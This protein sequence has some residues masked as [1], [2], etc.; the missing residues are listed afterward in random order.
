MLLKHRHAK[1]ST[2]GVY[3]QDRILQQTA[4]QPGTHFAYLLDPHHK[5]LV[6]LPSSNATSHTVS[7]RQTHNTV[8]PVIDLRRRDILET[9]A[10]CPLWNIDICDDTITITGLTADTPRLPQ[11]SVSPALPPVLDLAALCTS[12]SRIT[13]TYS[14]AGLAH[15]IGSMQLGFAFAD[16][17]TAP[18]SPEIAPHHLP[19]LV[20]SLFSGAGLLDLGFV[21]EG[22]T[23]AVA[24]EKNPAAAQTYQR[25]FGHQ[26]VLSDIY[27]MPFGRFS[28]P[29]MIGGSPCQGFS[30]ANRNSHFLDN[31]QNALVKAYI[32]RIQQ[33]P[34]C[35]I[36]VL[37]NVP[38]ILT[39]GDG[40]F[41][42]EILHA[43]QDFTVTYGVLDAAD[44]GTP[45]H[46]RRAF[47][48]G[49]KIG[50]I[51]LPRPGF[52]PWRT[53]RQ[54]FHGLHATIPNQT[55]ISQP[56]PLTRQRMA[57]V[58]P[59]GNVQNIPPDLRPQGTHSDMYKRLMWDAPSVT[60][61]HPRK[62]LLLHP[63]EDR[64][65][66][67]RECAR[68]QDVPD[69]FVFTGSLDAKQQQVANG[70]PVRLSQAI[71]ATVKAAIQQWTIRTAHAVFRS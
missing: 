67:V 21:Q 57:Q 44:F 10:T 39:A 23:I 36:F 41:R 16:T 6:I 18:L 69:D 17:T 24:V 7:K 34:A 27:E 1:S 45:Q 30:N 31:P 52:Q 51:A 33:N 71:A 68:L 49:S 32:D 40:Q 12:R 62:A 38:Q 15:A 59:G 14:R 63:A 43:L 50:P 60:I 19:L 65:L 35:Q 70:V 56:T 58:P 46:R 64:I 26:M 13:L 8:N 20:D 54:A 42:D 5:T 48:L 53:V 37:E 3:L 4:F 2:R 25:N 28:S 47:F 29:I 9:L 22:F 61:V 66:S 11:P 55:D